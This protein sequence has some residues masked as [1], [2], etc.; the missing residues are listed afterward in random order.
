MLLS[1]PE[2]T[3]IC[4]GCDKN[5]M[6]E[7]MLAHFE[8]CSGKLN[9][10]HENVYAENETIFLIKV[11]TDTIFWVYVE[12]FANSTLAGL[13][14]FLRS[15]WFECCGH[16]SPFY[17]N[18]KVVADMQKTLGEALHTGSHFHYEH[19]AGVAM[20]VVG[21][22]ICIK[23]NKGDKNIRLVSRKKISDERCA[24]CKDGKDI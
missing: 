6:A 13:Y 7:N 9:C 2:N 24:T 16:V 8:E 3:G 5:I 15:N 19:N 12:A 20:A 1:P 21:E 4:F 10:M 22:V 14:A 18:G 11:V 17:L 23:Q